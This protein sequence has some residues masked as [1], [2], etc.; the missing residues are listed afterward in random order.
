[1]RAIEIAT[2]NSV[3]VIEHNLEAI[4][5]ADC[6]IDLGPCSRRVEP[7]CHLAIVLLAN[8]KNSN[9]TVRFRQHPVARF[10]SCDTQ[11]CQDR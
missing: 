6:I 7:E 3:V 8:P 9:H 4:K 2:L 1:M 5:T 10:S 11:Q